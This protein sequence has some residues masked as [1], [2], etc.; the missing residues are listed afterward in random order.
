MKRALI[1][2]ILAATAACGSYHL[3]GTTGGTGTVSGSV[4]VVPCG[5]VQPADKACA[6]RFAGLELDFSSGGTTV[7]TTTDSN[8][9]YTV[10]LAAG[11]WNVS[12]VK[13]TRIVSGPRSITVHAGDSIVANYIV[14]SGIRV[15]VAAG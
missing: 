9:N 15:P 6:G 7:S 1:V 10:N 2:V 5:P 4:T 11:T 12:V 14:D 13:L 8:G 3:P